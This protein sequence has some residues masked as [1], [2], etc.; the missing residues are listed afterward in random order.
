MDNISDQELPETSYVKSSIRIQ[1]D[2]VTSFGPKNG[3]LWRGEEADPNSLIDSLKKVFE[4]G[5]SQ[6]GEQSVL[7]NLPYIR[8][9]YPDFICASNTY[10]N[11]SLWVENRRNYLLGYMDIFI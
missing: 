3:F 4:A 7:A 8:Q 6:G 9:N 2:V 1:G 10:S 11:Q 5:F